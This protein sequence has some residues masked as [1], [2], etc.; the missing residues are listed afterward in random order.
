MW[1]T[2]VQIYNELIS[3]RF[4]THMNS[5]VWVTLGNFVGHLAKSGKCLVEERP[6]GLFIMYVEKDPEQVRRQ[7][8]ML[9]TRKYELDEEARNMEFIKDLVAKAHAGAEPDAAPVVE[10]EAHAIDLA[11]LDKGAFAFSLKPAAKRGFGPTAA[12][13][14]PVAKAGPVPAAAA[15]SSVVPPESSAAKAGSDDKAEAEADDGEGEPNEGEDGDGDGDG[16]GMYIDEYGRLRSLAED[17]EEDEADGQ[18]EQQQGVN[19]GESNPIPAAAAAVA[20]AAPT[21]PSQA[22]AAPALTPVAPTPALAS[23]PVPASGPAPAPKLVP[24]TE[25]PAAA[26]APSR[27]RE[28]ERP[29]PSKDAKASEPKRKL[30]AIEEIMLAEEQKKDKVWTLSQP[31]ASLRRVMS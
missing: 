12:A 18:S 2:V 21:A 5:T 20:N 23:A 13:S 27:P 7:E 8:S 26:A 28:P 25:P 10:P 17:A 6:K 11:A 22:P 31:L 1:L 4:H 14:A 24:K 29:M 3:D 9:K 30:T 16:G 15:P 19:G